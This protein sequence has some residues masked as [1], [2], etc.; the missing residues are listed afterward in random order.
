MIILTS[1]ENKSLEYIE[2]F[3]RFI[4]HKS[5]IYIHTY[6]AIYY[7]YADDK[8]QRN[9]NKT[10]TKKRLSMLCQSKEEMESLSC[11]IMRTVWN[12]QS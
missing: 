12:F 1:I 2:F 5:Q 3:M 4:E 7:N 9:S 6:I 8:Q 10:I 11:N